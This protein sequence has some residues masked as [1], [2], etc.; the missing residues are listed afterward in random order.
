MVVLRCQKKSDPCLAMFVRFALKTELSANGL[1]H[2]HNSSIGPSVQGRE[3]V[4]DHSTLRKRTQRH[5]GE[6]DTDK[7]ADQL[8]I[9]MAF[10]VRHKSS[11]G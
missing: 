11:G 8:A 3:P 6:A 9:D 5:R 10:L 4:A 2:S 7:E 1:S